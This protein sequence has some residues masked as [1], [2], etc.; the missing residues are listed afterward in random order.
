[1]VG[2]INVSLK[3]RLKERNERA[4]KIFQNKKWNTITAYC[5]ERVQLSNNTRDFLF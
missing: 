5:F 1:M 4:S 3:E 2:R